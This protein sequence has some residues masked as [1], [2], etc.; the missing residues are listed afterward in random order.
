VIVQAEKDTG[1]VSIRDQLLK[2]KKVNI[3]Q[4]KKLA[5][6]ISLS[7]ESALDAVAVQGFLLNYT[8]Q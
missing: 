5:A 8:K 1:F 2:Y 4:G 7:R 3:A 6:K